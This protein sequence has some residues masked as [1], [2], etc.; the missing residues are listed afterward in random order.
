M[1]MLEDK[2]WGCYIL[3]NVLWICVKTNTTE[4]DTEFVIVYFKDL[5]HN[6]EIFGWYFKQ[7]QIYSE[8]NLIL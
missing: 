1:F 6:L 4:L 8:G 7:I 2:I 5:S 3:G